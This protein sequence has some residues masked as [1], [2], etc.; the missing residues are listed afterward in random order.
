MV[1]SLLLSFGIVTQQENDLWKLIYYVA[2]QPI[3]TWKRWGL[4]FLH[5]S[6]I[7]TKA[8]ISDFYVA[9]VIFLLCSWSLFIFWCII[10]MFWNV[11]SWVTWCFFSVRASMIWNSLLR[12]VVAAESLKVFKWR[13]DTHLN[14]QNVQGNVYIQAE[15]HHSL[16]G[17][18][19]ANVGQARVLRSPLHS[20]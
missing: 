4:H 20:S 7:S 12:S 16:C 6:F 5:S 11:N 3:G 10:D 9:C 17:V 2:M 18:R 19:T 14:W 8:I 13:L 1:S 15:I